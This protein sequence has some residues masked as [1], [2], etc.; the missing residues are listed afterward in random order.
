ML[1]NNIPFSFLIPFSYD[2]QSRMFPQ[3]TTSQCTTITG[4]VVKG[5]GH[6]DHV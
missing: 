2:V 4:R 6:L 1:Y 3:V 5:V